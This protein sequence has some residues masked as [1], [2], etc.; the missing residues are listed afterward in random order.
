MKVKNWDHSFLINSHEDCSLKEKSGING[1]KDCTGA[2]PNYAWLTLLTS[3]IHLDTC[4]Q[5]NTVTKKNLRYFYLD[6]R[7]LKVCFRQYNFFTRVCRILE[8]SG[9]NKPLSHKTPGKA[10]L[11]AS[12]H[13]TNYKIHLKPPCL[14]HQV[15]RTIACCFS[16]LWQWLNIH[17]INQ[18]EKK[19]NK[20]LCNLGNFQLFAKAATSFPVLCLW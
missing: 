6:F 19:Q 9:Y 13:R 2:F 12:F 1:N 16:I 3:N 8:E 10:L 4:K 15:S 18:W 14:S 20:S 7:G 17:K 5:K 11:E